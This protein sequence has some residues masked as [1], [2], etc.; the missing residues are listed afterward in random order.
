LDAELLV[1]LGPEPVPQRPARLLVRA[2]RA[3]D[4]LLRL[5]QQLLVD[6]GRQDRPGQ[7][8]GD[9]LPAA[10][11][12]PAGG[13]PGADLLHLGALGTGTVRRSGR[14]GGDRLR[15]A[16]LPRGEHVRRRRDGVPLLPR[17]GRGRRFLLGHAG[18]ELH[19]RPAEL[20]VELVDGVRLPDQPLGLVHAVRRLDAPD[21]NAHPVRLRRLD[22][23]HHVLV[24]GDEHDVAHRAVPGQ[25]LE[26]L[27]QLRIDAFLLAGRV[28]VAEPDLDVRERGDLP[29]LDR[30]HPVPGGVVP[31]HPQQHAGRGAIGPGHQGPDQ[32]L[33]RDPELPPRRAA[34]D[35]LAGGRVEIARVH[36]H[37]VP[38]DVRNDVGHCPS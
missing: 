30:V 38:A 12:Q 25:Q 2:E 22:R 13:D 36:Q 21:V 24:A 17:L 1:Q 3:A 20:G 33:G 7:Q 9:V 27:P 5:D 6:D 31:V 29:L 35:Q 19:V 18:L 23:G 32:R 16:Q 11:E 15:G 10:G 28:E 26:V 4:L 37:G 14:R 34:E 8:I